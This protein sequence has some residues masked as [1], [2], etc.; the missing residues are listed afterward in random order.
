MRKRKPA[1]PKRRKSRTKKAA[2]IARK[3]AATAKKRMP[4]KVKAKEKRV[5]RVDK[6]PHDQKPT[7]L[8]KMKEL[9]ADAEDDEDVLLDLEPQGESDKN[10]ETREYITTQSDVLPLLVFQAGYIQPNIVHS[11]GIYATSARKRD[12]WDK[13]MIGAI[14]KRE[15]EDDV[16]WISLAT[17]HFKWKDVVIPTIESDESDL[18][19]TFYNERKNRGKFFK[20]DSVQEE[21]RVLVNI[22][23]VVMLPTLLGPVFADKK[24]GM[25]AVCHCEGVGD[26]TR[27]VGEGIGDSDSPLANLELV[28][29]E[30]Y[31]DQRGRNKKFRDRHTADSEIEG[32]DETE[33]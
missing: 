16:V 33:T 31:D 18:M 15:T 17:S 21:D 22:P 23:Q 6:E 29:G 2:P 9:A 5:E 27:H 8:E 26:A 1:T 19:S 32:V 3:I 14:G 24:N 13:H 25:G 7:L 10:E 12:M 30:E 20:L 4:P 28:T 11:V